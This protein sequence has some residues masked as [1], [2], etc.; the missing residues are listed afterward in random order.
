MEFSYITGGQPP[1]NATT[2]RALECV[3]WLDNTG[4][5]P[6]TWWVAIHVRFL[7]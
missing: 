3:N 2:K 5:Y 7:I 1:L 4:N 6:W